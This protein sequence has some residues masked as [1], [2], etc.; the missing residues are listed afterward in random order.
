MELELSF[1]TRLVPAAIISISSLEFII[2]LDLFFL[3]L[4]RTFFVEVVILN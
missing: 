1:T 4:L 2:V 3:E